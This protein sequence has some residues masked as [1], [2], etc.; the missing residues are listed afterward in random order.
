[1]GNFAKGRDNT[2]ETPK[3]PDIQICSMCTYDFVYPNFRGQKPDGNHII[4]RSA[5]GGYI[6]KNCYEQGEHAHNVQRDEFFTRHNDGMWGSLYRASHGLDSKEDKI[7]FL[8][9]LRKQISGGFGIPLPYRQDASAEE[10]D[11]ETDALDEGR[12]AELKERARRAVEAYQD[13]QR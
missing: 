11:A 13:R 1:M 9:L 10:I 2:E 5:N 6:C 4:G 3:G 8:K 12:A 7:D